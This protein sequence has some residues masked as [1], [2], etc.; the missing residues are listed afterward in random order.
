MWIPLAVH[1]AVLRA[2]MGAMN[3][4]YGMLIRMGVDLE[5]SEREVEELREI[6][7]F[8]RRVI[9]FFVCLLAFLLVRRAGRKQVPDGDGV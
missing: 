4:Q 8:Y 1:K 7:R 3:G 2:A 5:S 9:N 6:N